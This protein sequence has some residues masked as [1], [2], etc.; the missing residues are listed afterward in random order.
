MAVIHG[1]LPPTRADWLDLKPPVIWIKWDW[2]FRWKGQHVC[3]LLGVLSSS[4]FPVTEEKSHPGCSVASFTCG[5]RLIG[6]QPL[7]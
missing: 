7:D 1:S 4:L 3:V 5:R 2:M 6:S